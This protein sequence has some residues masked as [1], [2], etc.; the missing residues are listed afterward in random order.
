MDNNAGIF[1][2]GKNLS[3]AAFED[4]ENKFNISR[5]MWFNKPI[6]VALPFCL[7]NPG[8]YMYVEG[9]LVQTM[10]PLSECTSNQDLEKAVKDAVAHMGEDIERLYCQYMHEGRGWDSKLHNSQLSDYRIDGDKSGHVPYVEV[11]EFCSQNRLYERYVAIA[12]NLI[13]RTRDARIKR[14]TENQDTYAKWAIE[15]ASSKSSFD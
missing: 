6:E 13:T 9:V 3:A 10:L 12:S 4:I 11:V 7:D 2:I 14:F 5:R 1:I 8:K 15:K